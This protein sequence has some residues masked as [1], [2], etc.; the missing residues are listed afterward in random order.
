MWFYCYGRFVTFGLYLDENP[1]MLWMKTF[2]VATSTTL[3]NYLSPVSLQLEIGRKELHEENV[4][5]T[6]EGKE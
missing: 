4:N 6:W 3:K 2:L 1:T 5:G